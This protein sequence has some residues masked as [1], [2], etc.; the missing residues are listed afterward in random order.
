MKKT[1]QI[2]ALFTLVATYVNAQPKS[3]A[4]NNGDNLIN[5]GI[6]VGSPFFGTGY[7]NSLPVNPTISVEHG[8]TDQISAGAQI[9]YASTK[10]NYSYVGDPY[11]F[12]ESA[13]Y[14][15]VRGSYH[16]GEVFGLGNKFDVY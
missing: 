5:I 9:S 3:A 15:G 12:K 11:T 16:L 10:Y 6:G 1:L 2:I 4:F 13:T 14:V 7:S 8:F